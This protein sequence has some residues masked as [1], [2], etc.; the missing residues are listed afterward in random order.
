MFKNTRSQSI[1]FTFRK[2]NVATQI[3]RREI[4]SRVNFLYE[5]VEKGL[6]HMYDHECYFEH[7]RLGELLIILLEM[8][9]NINCAKV[10]LDEIYV[11]SNINKSEIKSIVF[12]VSRLMEKIQF[13]DQFEICKCIDDIRMST[14]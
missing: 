12:L 14:L 2:M 9:R 5:L 11:Y 8:S 6:V 13:P 4:G 1:Y 7:E 3:A 10:I